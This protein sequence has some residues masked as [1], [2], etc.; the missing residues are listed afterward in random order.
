MTSAADP[1][2][3]AEPVPAPLTVLFVC[4]ANICRSAYAAARAADFVPP[5]GAL[6]IRSAGIPG[7]VGEPMS[8]EMA[9]VLA[10]RGR[11]G[12]AH[13]SRSVTAQ[14]VA[15]AD[16]VL[17]MEARHRLAIIDELPTAAPIVFTIAQADAALAAIPG[18]VRGRDLVT[19][20]FRARRPV[21]PE[22]D[23]VD[24]YRRGLAAN[25]ATADQLDAVLARIV[26]RLAR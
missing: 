21:R 6:E 13:R 7:L 18:A 15:E 10:E 8:E 9:Q 22:D 12:S 24:P 14:V 20:I 25:R 16:L 17:T 2:S 1:R 26:P 4:T 5:G 11:D 23:V 19:A 3:T